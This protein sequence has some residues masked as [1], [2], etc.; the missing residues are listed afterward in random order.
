MSQDSVKVRKDSFLASKPVKSRSP[1]SSFGKDE[2]ALA[3]FQRFN[4]IVTF[5]IR[6]V[7][8]KM[9]RTGKGKKK[10]TT[11]TV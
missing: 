4:V 11:T 10:Q 2:Y 1:V 6:S 8:S 5:E 9:V 3:Q 7:S